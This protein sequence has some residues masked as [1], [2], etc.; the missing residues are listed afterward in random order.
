MSDLEKYV[1]EHRQKFDVAT[2]DA[3][4]IWK[5]ISKELEVPAKPRR[6]NPWRRTAVAASLLVLITLGSLG[7]YSSSIGHVNPSTAHQ[8][9]DINKHYGELI[10]LKIELI[11]KNENISEVE[12]RA[13]VEELKELD[14]DYLKLKKELNLNIDNVKVLEAIIEN[15]TT[16]LRLIENFLARLNGS[17]SE[18]DDNSIE[19]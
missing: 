16:R 9:V 1:K 3:D 5:A 7:Y 6:V 2:P 17:Q 4:K 10:A 12:K 11:N 8:L 19:V 18:I 13:F 14:N 15:Y